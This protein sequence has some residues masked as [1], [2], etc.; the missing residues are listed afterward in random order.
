MDYMRYALTIRVLIGGDTTIFCEPGHFRRDTGVRNEV[1]GVEKRVFIIIMAS[2][3]YHEMLEMW[4]RRA[5]R[6]Y[7][8]W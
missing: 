4:K 7:L 6:V 5:L 2:E 3:S 1:A 8:S